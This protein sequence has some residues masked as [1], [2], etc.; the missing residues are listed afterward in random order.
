MGK[1]AQLMKQNRL[2]VRARDIDWR[3]RS[4][5]WH[6]PVIRGMARVSMVTVMAR[7]NVEAK[8]NILSYGDACLPAGLPACMHA[9]HNYR[10]Q[11]F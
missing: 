11:A 1:L 7:V 5:P 2:R 4:L 9:Y 8:L 3:L 6:R 10:G